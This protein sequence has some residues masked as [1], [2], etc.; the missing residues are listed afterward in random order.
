MAN[1]YNLRK[2]SSNEINNAIRYNDFLILELKEI[3]KSNKDKA[4][5]MYNVELSDK[6][7]CLTKNAEKV[8]K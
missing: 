1:S 3:I 7:L 4:I 5:R 2:F 8:L 6:K